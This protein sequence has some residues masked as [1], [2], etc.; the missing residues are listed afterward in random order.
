MMVIAFFSDVIRLGEWDLETDVDCTNTTSGF[1]LCSPQ[2]ARD[3]EYEEIVVHPTYGKRGSLS[4]NIALIRLAEPIDFK[5]NC[6][7]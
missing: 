1:L 5:K 4:D 3:V 7:H 6:K 2:P